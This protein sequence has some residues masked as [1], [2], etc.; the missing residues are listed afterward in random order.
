MTNKFTKGFYIVRF[1]YED[2]DAQRDCCYTKLVYAESIDELHRVLDNCKD[3]AVDY[4][5]A[6]VEEK[7]MHIQY[8]NVL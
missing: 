5:E 7:L 1:E 4:W 8:G 3:D 2:W 6:S